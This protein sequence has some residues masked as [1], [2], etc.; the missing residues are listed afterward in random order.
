MGRGSGDIRGEVGSGHEHDDRRFPP[1][2]AHSGDGGHRAD[3]QGDPGD[4]VARRSRGRMEGDGRGSPEIYGGDPETA[5]GP[6]GGQPPLFG[7]A[8]AYSSSHSGPIPDPG[9]MARYGEV[10]P[11]YPERIMRMTE[12]RVDV[13]VEAI[14]RDSRAIAWVTKAGGMVMVA[15]V[16][17]SLTLT[18]IALFLQLPWQIVV[19]CVTPASLTG[20]S[21]IIRSARGG[22]SEGDA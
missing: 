4:S 10:D 17:G 11:S 7:V 22:T 16:L 8:Q 21:Q 13:Q 14:D 18:A 6:H 20:I 1:G 2:D 5:E 19:A 3:A 15:L 9:T 12:K